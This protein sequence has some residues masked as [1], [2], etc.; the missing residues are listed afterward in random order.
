VKAVTW[1]NTV[2][3]ALT[4]VALILTNPDGAGR[5]SVVFTGLVQKIVPVLSE[6][7]WMAGTMLVANAM[8]FVDIV[9]L[10]ALTTAAEV[11]QYTAL[12]YVAQVILIYPTA[13]AQTLGPR[14]AALY[15][16]GDKDGVRIALN[17]YM[18]QS[19]LLGGYLFAGVAVFGSQLDL[20][21]GH[22]FQISWAM[23]VLLAFGWYV[24]ATLGQLGFMLSMTGYHH[25]EFA[26]M[27]V[28]PVILIGSLWVFIPMMRDTGAALSVAI[29]FSVVNVA[30]TLWSI[31]LLRINPLQ[32]RDIAPPI[33]F[34]ILALLSLALGQKTGQRALP[35]LIAECAVYSVLAASAFYI[36]FASADERSRLSAA[37]RFCS[38]PVG[39]F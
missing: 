8:R 34:S 25:H 17:T 1:V 33:V 29:A 30:R 28:G 7:L 32:V 14:V 11:G 18:R 15:R 2:T 37:V 31:R 26:F 20:V 3:Y 22:G 4:F 35:V 13:G 9:M 39:D 27:S 19:A 10:A 5:I 36:L 12:S 6:S 38:R 16:D 24:A 21:F 23:A